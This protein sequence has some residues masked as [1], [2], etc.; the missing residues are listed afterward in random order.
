[1][2]QEVWERRL[3]LLN[4][5][6]LARVKLRRFE[7]WAAIRLSHVD[8]QAEA[9]GQLL[10]VGVDIFHSLRQHNSNFKTEQPAILL[11]KPKRDHQRFCDCYTQSA[12]IGRQ[13][14]QKNML[15]Q[16]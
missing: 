5:C 9:I 2:L 14:L 13:L 7:N 6:S 3:K 8:D 16:T 12:I 1:M 10:P 15:V 11:K 4:G